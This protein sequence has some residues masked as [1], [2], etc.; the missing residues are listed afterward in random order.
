MKEGEILKPQ[1][2][3][4]ELFCSLPP[5]IPLVFYGGAAGGGKSWSLL[6]YLLRFVDDPDFYGVCFRKSL[7]QL[8]RALWKEA[9]KMYRPLITDSDGKYIGKAKINDSQGNFKVT[10]PSGAVIEFSY[11]SSEKDAIEGLTR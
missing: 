3:P 11:L 7:K 10:F 2:G 5:E 8:E 9:K 6:F 1:E 4:Q